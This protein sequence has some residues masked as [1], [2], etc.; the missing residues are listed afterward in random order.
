[1]EAE[2]RRDRTPCPHPTLVP[3]THCRHKSSLP[4]Q[5]PA[6]P[7][8][9]PLLCGADDLHGGGTPRRT[10]GSG[11]GLVVYGP[12]SARGGD[13]VSYQWMMLMPAY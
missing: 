7:P 9:P 4:L 2:T 13:W 8:P 10:T 3:P 11:I 12:C 1:M 5:Y 6:D